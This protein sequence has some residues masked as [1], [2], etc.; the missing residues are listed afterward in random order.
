MPSRPVF[1]ATARIDGIRPLLRQLRTEDPVFSEPWTEGLT[2]ATKYAHRVVNSRAPYLTGNLQARIT[3]KIQAKPV[4][5][6]GR[7]TANASSHGVRYGF[8]L[9]AGHRKQVTL[10]YHGT[11]RPTK[12]WFTSVLHDL[13]ARINQIL[14]RAAAETEKRWGH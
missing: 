8:V 6:W 3:D 9:N 13:Q 1:R 2:E 7:V 10:H 14:S 4:P 5:T 12:G 11:S